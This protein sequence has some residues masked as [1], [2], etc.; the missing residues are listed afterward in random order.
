MKVLQVLQS[1]DS[2]NFSDFYQFVTAI[3]SE[4]S[5]SLQSQS[6][7]WFILQ[8]LCQAVLREHSTQCLIHKNTEIRSTLIRMFVELFVAEGKEETAYDIMESLVV[9]SAFRQDQNV[10]LYFSIIK[11]LR[12]IEN[13]ERYSTENRSEN[14]T[15]SHDYHLD[16]DDI[17]LDTSAAVRIE[18]SHNPFSLVRFLRSTENSHSLIQL[19]SEIRQVLDESNTQNCH[20]VGNISTTSSVDFLCIYIAI[21]HGIDKH[22]RAKKQLKIIKR[23][24]RASHD[25]PMQGIACLASWRVIQ[26]YLTFHGHKRSYILHACS[27]WVH[28]SDSNPH[29]SPSVVFVATILYKL[30]E[31]SDVS[32]LKLLLHQIESS[33]TGVSI[34]MQWTLWRSLASLL[35]DVHRISTGEEK[36]ERSGERKEERGERSGERNGERG[37]RGEGGDQDLNVSSEIQ[38]ELMSRRWWEEYLFDSTQLHNQSTDSSLGLG[39]SVQMSSVQKQE[40]KGY[41]YYGTGAIIDEDD[42]TTD[43]DSVKNRNQHKCELKGKG[44]YVEARRVFG[45]SHNVYSTQS[46]KRN[47]KRRSSWST[48]DGSESEER[49][50]SQESEALDPEET[51]ATL[52]TE[53]TCMY[54]ELLNALNNG[55]SSSMRFRSMTS[56]KDDHCFSSSEY[57]RF[58]ILNSLTFLLS[59]KK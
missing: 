26:Y 19:C 18:I 25:H 51:E 10:K 27:Q 22:K 4:Y 2:I 20:E 55:F 50:Q 8:R 44:D 45:E 49:S 39:V 42:I 43:Y 32:F 34:R 46:G 11:C 59:E 28:A 24:S 16:G 6:Q 5:N 23:I 35:E 21:L 58:I 41:G 57:V 9:D 29:F 37:G 52:D 30:K 13:D 1:V 54:M 47:R 12:L 3:R 36:E 40:L 14:S 15:E 33:S 56:T 31:L 53:R 7:Y 17:S 48:S 38:A